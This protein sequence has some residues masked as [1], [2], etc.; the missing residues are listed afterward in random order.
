MFILRLRCCTYLSYRRVV[1]GKG[2][3]CG[4]GTSLESLRL[5]SQSTPCP[6]NSPNLLP[7]HSSVTRFTQS[8]SYP[9]QIP[10]HEV[11]SRL[12]AN[13]AQ[14]LH[15]QLYTSLLAPCRHLSPTTHPSPNLDREKNHHNVAV[16]LHIVSHRAASARSPGRI[17]HTAERDFRGSKQGREYL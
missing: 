14:L 6:R 15:N 17:G 12:A 8:T 3:G 4:S 16:S 7:T 5:S 10:G 2:K 13:L 11:I 9:K 1:K